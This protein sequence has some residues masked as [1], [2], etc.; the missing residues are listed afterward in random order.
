MDERLVTLI[1]T[2]GDIELRT[3]ADLEFYGY[4]IVR[5]GREVVSSEHEFSTIE[6]ARGDA[7]HWLLQEAWSIVIAGSLIVVVSLIMIFVLVYGWYL[8]E[9]IM[10]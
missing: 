8:G 3:T 2:T 5:K 4:R 10:K 1:E 6:A 7:R 9:T